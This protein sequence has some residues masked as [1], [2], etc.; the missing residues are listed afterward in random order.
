VARL[1]LL[2]D[3]EIAAR[4]QVGIVPLAAVDITLE[5]RNHVLVSIRVKMVNLVALV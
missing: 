3:T 4:Q 2:D 5:H 1:V